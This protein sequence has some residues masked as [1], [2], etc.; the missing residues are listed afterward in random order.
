VI[1]AVTTWVDDC[2]D[3]LGPVQQARVRV[4]HLI[5]LFLVTV[6]PA[7]GLLFWYCGLTLPSLVM[8]VLPCAAVPALFLLTRRGQSELGGRIMS[9]V[10]FL[11]ILNALIG[12]GG[13]DSNSAA[14]LLCSPLLGFTMVGP[15]HGRNLSI[16]AALVFGA[17]WAAEFFGS[18]LPWHLPPA[19]TAVMPVLDYPAIALIFGAILSTQVSIWEGL[20]QGM[21]TTNQ[22][23]ML[24]IEERKRAE[25][26]ATQAVKARTTFLATMSHEI[27]TPLNGVLGLTQVLLDSK[28]DADQQQLAK[29]VQS[30]GRLLRSLL[31]DVLDYSKIDSGQMEVERIPLD[32]PAL[33]REMVLLWEERARGNGVSLCFMSQPESPNWVISDP[34]KLRQILG[35]LVSNAIKFTNNGSVR[36]LLSRTVDH[37]VLEVQDTGIGMET[38]ALA[39]IFEAFRQADGSTTRRYGGTGLGLAISKGLAIRMDGQ[40]GVHST[41]GQ[42]T[43]FTLKLPL[44]TAV[45]PPTFAPGAAWTKNTLTGVEVLVAEDNPVNQMVIRR[46][47]ER[48]GL[49]VRITSNGQEC[50]DAY[51]HRQP[52]L[53]LMDCQMPICDGYQAT[54]A[55][56][57]AGATLPIIALTANT[58]PGDKAKCLA[59]GMS[60]HSGKPIEIIELLECIERWQTDQHA[61]R[62]SRL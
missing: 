20:I 61:C 24:E 7:Y 33:C 35:N 39:H 40:L 21:H 55:L 25:L 14:W 45:A 30:S 37:L 54:I 43:S 50:Q 46:L 2:T 26:Q 22:R 49:T 12:R 60:D 27:R 23:A 4:Q 6:A 36:I 56:R 31:D 15:R 42:G 19:L 10:S 41:L 16:C 51:H 53:I 17:V 28:L 3:G 38:Q 34:T 32:L 44:K 52:D 59:A 48:S 11:V 58:M 29:T 57:E 13:M 47:L 9:T 5:A 18:P 62:L 8:T 1:S